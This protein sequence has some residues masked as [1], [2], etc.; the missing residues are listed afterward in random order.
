MISLI[1][2]V[3][4][5]VLAGTVVGLLVPDQVWVAAG[6]GVLGF[7]LAAVAQHRL[8]LR[9]RVSAPDPLPA[10]PPPANQA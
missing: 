4:V 1:N 3:I 9:W 2:S 7:A 5:G 6:V 8:Q 10:L